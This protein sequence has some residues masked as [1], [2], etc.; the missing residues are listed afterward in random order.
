MHDDDKLPPF[1]PQVVVK[2]GELIKATMSESRVTYLA[3][4][5]DIR[6]GTLRHGLWTA[7]GGY[8][9]ASEISDDTH[10]RVT[11]DTGLEVW[12]PLG[13]LIRLFGDSE[14]MLEW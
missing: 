10:L 11:L 4:D 13:R 14:L 9:R 12:L 6:R 3:P 7:E 5:G 2:L 1:T 8:Q